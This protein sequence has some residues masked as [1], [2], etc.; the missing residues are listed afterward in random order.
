MKYISN[1]YALKGKLLFLEYYEVYNVVH[2]V[3]LG[4]ITKYQIK[5]TFKDTAQM[6]SNL[7]CI[8]FRRHSN[9]WFALMKCLRLSGDIFANLLFYLSGGD[10]WALV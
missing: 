6:I 9:S 4:L 3:P 5:S 10:R 7:L 2:K 1:N 8:I